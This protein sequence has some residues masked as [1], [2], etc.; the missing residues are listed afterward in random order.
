MRSAERWHLAARGLQRR[1]VRTLLTLL[2]LV[3]AVT[4]MLLFLSLGEGLKGQLRQELRSAR[5]DLQVARPAGGLALLPGPNLPGALVTTLKAQAGELGLAE[6]TPVAAEI[7]QALDPTQSAVYYGL[8]ARQGVQAL[9][10][11]ARAAQGRLLLPEDEGRAVAVLGASAARNLGL[12]VGGEFMVSRRYRA[13]I[14]GV[15]QPL[16]NLTD[17]FTFLPLTGAQRAFGTGDQL[18]F[19]ALKLR[20]PEQAP[21]IAAQLRRQL[22]LEVS[23]RDDVLHSAG[24]VLRSADAL[25]LGLSLVALV[26]GGLAVANTMLMT[27]HERTREFALLR[28]I[29]AR[30]QFLRQL[31]LSESLLLAGLSWAAGVLLSVPGVWAINWMTQRV[32]G[33][34][35]AAL[36]PRLLAL[37]LGLSLLLGLLAGW[38]PAY[39]AGR[40]SITRAL[41]QP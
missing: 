41:G 17:T 2:G 23:T 37:T 24:Q 34:D 16:N 30:P 20:D 29:G 10:P 22:Q 25:S 28:A 8:P 7:K 38:W 12:G 31:V 40:T 21:Q 27:L 6:I 15:L 9:F 13:R 39:R 33:I 35:G 4:S 14:V 5:P 11:R 32:A 36:T 1:P 18:S 26:V 3:V 19:V